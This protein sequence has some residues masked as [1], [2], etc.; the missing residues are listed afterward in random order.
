MVPALQILVHAGIARSIMATTG[1]IFKAAGRPG[2][3]TKWQVVRLAILACLIYPFIL[4]WQLAGA[5][6]AVFL[7]NS[8]STI[9]FCFSV[10]RLLKCRF[11]EFA[12]AVAPS[13]LLFAGMIAAMALINSTTGSSGIIRIILLLVVQFCLIAGFVCLFEKIFGYNIKGLLTKG[14]GRFE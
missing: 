1:P 11:R 13:F 8:L 7:S 14:I 12:A 3:G 4:R 5:S 10:L 6:M 2:T 9:G